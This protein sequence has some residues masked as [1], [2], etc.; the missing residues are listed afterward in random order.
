[1][2]H[3]LDFTGKVALVRGAAGMG[4]T[5]GMLAVAS[6][7]ALALGGAVAGPAENPAS[8]PATRTART[9]TMTVAIKVGTKTFT[10]TLEDNAT[11]TAFKALLPAT[12]RMT[13]LNGN[14]KYFRF[15]GNLPT[16]A[17]N[18]GTIQTGDLM[19]YGQNTLVLFYKTFSTSYSY[20]RLGR[21][22]DPAGLATAF[23]SGDVTVTYGMQEK[24]KGN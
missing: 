5:V 16:N 3:V 13:E 19:I 4:F 2:N 10:A 7:G 18:P 20:T 17:S 21:I 1:M 15:S 24:A 23:G 9:N 14:E 22:D 8:A 12:V 11:V 6:I